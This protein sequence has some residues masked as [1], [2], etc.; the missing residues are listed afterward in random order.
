M[1]EKIDLIKNRTAE[2]SAKKELFQKNLA[3]YL[4]IEL[5]SYNQ[6]NASD[7]SVFKASEEKT[8]EESEAKLAE[9][10][11]YLDFLLSFL[12]ATTNA[13]F[14]LGSMTGTLI[15]K[16]LSDYFGRRNSLVVQNVFTLIA[17]VLILL[18]HYFEHFS[19]IMLSRLFFGV[20][21]G[22]SHKS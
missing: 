4:N 12:W 20:Q 15:S 14:A 9:D 13:L 7:S 5:N 18:L 16:P 19:L 8:L 11:K 22:K 3:Q 1:E 10:S 17:V 6:E 21:G 2:L